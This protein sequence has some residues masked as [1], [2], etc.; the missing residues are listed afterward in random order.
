MIWYAW[1]AVSLSIDASSWPV[2]VTV[3]AAAQLVGVNVRVAESTIAS[4]VSLLATA[5]VTSAVGSLDSA[6]VNESAPPASVVTV[7]PPLSTT[8]RP[9]VSSSV[10]VSAAPATE[11]TIP[12]LAAVP[13]TVTSRSGAS[14]SL[15]AAMIVA[16]SEAF[17][18]SPIGIVMVASEPTV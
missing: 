5:T 7:S 13:V 3:C 17:E 14:M 16:V 8:A 9:A 18:V 15:S 4:P 1:S 2:T 11:P 12:V 6:T 10:M